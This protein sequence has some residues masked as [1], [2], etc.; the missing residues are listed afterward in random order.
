MTEPLYATAR[1]DRPTD[2]GF[3]AE[4][5][6]GVL[7]VEL[8]G[9]QRLVADVG[10]ELAED[11]LPA[12]RNVVLG[13]PRQV[14]KSTLLGAV[15]LAVMIGEPGSLVLFS[16]QNRLSARSKL[17]DTWWPAIRRSRYA[18]EFHMTRATGTESLRCVNGSIMKIISAEPEAG[19]GESARLA[20]IDEA[21][22]LGP[23]V[24]QGLRA[25]TL[26]VTGSQVWITSTAGDMRSTW[27]RSKVE[28]GRNLA[29][30]DSGT[31][32]F[33]WAA[34]PGDDPVDPATWR[35]ANP[36]LGITI[37]ESVFAEDQRTLPPAEFARSHLNMWP[38]ADS[39]GWR[40]ISRELFDKQKAEVDWQ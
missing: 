3:V 18:S 12:Y 40:L 28:Q 35:K 15:M 5:A 11:G 1:S 36:A 30:S 33:E 13:T 26:A 17:F 38:D 10:C 2:G 34:S 29:K 20:V 16:A 21:W 25:A 8:M 23:E 14:G 4:V 6:G 19:H 24:E 39:H 37:D 32:F 9:W 22:A 31:A 27:W 7:G